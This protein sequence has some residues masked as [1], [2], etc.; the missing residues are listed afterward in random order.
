MNVMNNPPQDIQRW[1]NEDQAALRD[2]GNRL[3]SNLDGMVGAALFGEV[4]RA[5]MMLETEHTPDWATS[6]YNGFL[7]KYVERGFQ[8]LHN[9]Q[10]MKRIRGGPVLTQIVDNMLAVRANTG[11]GVPILV[12][13]AHAHHADQSGQCVG[14]RRQDSRAA[15]L[16][17]RVCHR[18]A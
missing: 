1:L 9:N 16:W 5:H 2:I 14:R 12:Y 8:L 4:I 6:A 15:A 13:S 11:T 3:G 7:Y 18:M 10:L 17:G